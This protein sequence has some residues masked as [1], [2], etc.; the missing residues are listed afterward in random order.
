MQMPLSFARPLAAVRR[1]AG[2]LRLRA[3]L[4]RARL[5][6]PRWP[7]EW[8]GRGFRGL[9]YTALALGGFIVLFTA[10]RL[11]SPSLIWPAYEARHD[12]A[13]GTALYDAKGRFLGILPG[14]LDPA[15]DYDVDED[16]KTLRLHAVPKDWWRVLVAL[17][18]E[19]FDSWRSWGGIDFVAVVAG[20]TRFGLNRVG[21]GG[22]RGRGGSSLAMQLVRS[23]NHIDPSRSRTFARKLLELKDGPILYDALGPPASN[24]GWRCTCRWSPAPATRAWASRSTGCARPA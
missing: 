15:G 5:F 21:L 3:R 12:R 20:F 2:R 7:Q 17:E 19:H 4:A 18:D 11:V 23:I 13:L 8:G 24:A 22:R 1:F 9:K 14:Q 6:G 16:H 10:H